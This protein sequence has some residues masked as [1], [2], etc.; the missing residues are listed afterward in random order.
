MGQ[1]HAEILK[2]L[3]VDTKGE[4]LIMLKLSG[5]ILMVMLAI[6]TSAAFAA[7]FP[8]GTYQA[9]DR[10]VTV[11]L[12][13]GKFEVH[14]GTES[15]VSGTYTVKGDQIA[16]TDVS[17]PGACK[18]AGQQTG[19]YSWKLSDNV[20]AFTKVSDR[21]DIRVRSLVSAVWKRET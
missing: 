9:G 19:L 21:C 6:L 16:I 14:K 4:D 1:D 20:L 18:T 17:G 7:D 8:T 5:S 10:A 13:G 15:T 12:E 2:R 11:K 3:R